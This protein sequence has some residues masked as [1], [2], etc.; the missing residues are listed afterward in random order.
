[1]VKLSKVTVVDKKD[2]ILKYQER[3]ICHQQQ[4]IL[5]RA[6]CV[7]IIN[8]NDELLLQQRS[9]Y[10]KLWPMFWSNSCCSHPLSQEKI[11]AESQKRLQEELGFST[12]L[13]FIDKFIYFFSYKDIGSEHE[14]AYVYMGDYSGAVYPNNKEVASYKWV[15]IDWLKKDIKQNPNDY[16][17]WF[18]LEF[19]ELVKRKL[20]R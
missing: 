18:K 2:Q 3:E 6:L 16:T 15:T 4:G 19:K 10:K 11:L 17:P 7:F 14:L 1:M 8:N 13:N 5:H 12:K 20:L 9:K